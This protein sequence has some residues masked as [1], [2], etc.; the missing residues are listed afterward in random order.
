MYFIKSFLLR[1]T[2]S[3][4]EVGSHDALSSILDCTSTLV[5]YYV[6]LLQSRNLQN[7]RIAGPPT[8][9]FLIT[10]SRIPGGVFVTA[11]L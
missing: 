6:G 5:W 7:C 1:F 2:A 8:T 9:N 10:G 3:S 11:Q 4:N